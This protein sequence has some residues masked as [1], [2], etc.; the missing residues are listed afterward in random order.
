MSFYNQFHFEKH[1]PSAKTTFTFLSPSMQNT[2]FL[3]SISV[4]PTIRSQQKLG[5]Q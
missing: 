2:A 1:S 5:N 3:E 4:V